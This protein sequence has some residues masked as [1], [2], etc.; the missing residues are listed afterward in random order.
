MK[1]YLDVL[2]WMWMID[3]MVFINIVIVYEYL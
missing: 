3:F 2:K 1:N